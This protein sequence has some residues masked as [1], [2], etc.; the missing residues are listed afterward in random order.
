MPTAP[1][2]GQRKRVHA[3]AT[4]YDGLSLRYEA[5]APV[6]AINERR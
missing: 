1:E 2:V 4:R 6:A 3:D 5:T